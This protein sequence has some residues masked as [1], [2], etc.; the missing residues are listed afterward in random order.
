MKFTGGSIPPELVVV[1]AFTV[2]VSYF[3]PKPMREMGIV[4]SP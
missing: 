1:L 4:M 2:T 3:F